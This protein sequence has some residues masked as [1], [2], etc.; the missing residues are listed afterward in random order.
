MRFLDES[1]FLTETKV[2]L[3]PLQKIYVVAEVFGRTITNIKAAMFVLQ[4]WKYWSVS[5][6]CDNIA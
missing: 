1:V 4:Y 3:K 6:N 5:F 2:F